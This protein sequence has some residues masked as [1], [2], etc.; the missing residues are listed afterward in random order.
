M[1]SNV[2]NDLI[3]AHLNMIMFSQIKFVNK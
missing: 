1:N 3:E 2:L